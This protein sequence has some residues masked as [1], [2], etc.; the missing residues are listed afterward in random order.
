MKCLIERP[1]P[2]DVT[3]ATSGRRSFA[4]SPLFSHFTWGIACRTLMDPHG[5]LF[6]YLEVQFFA[7]FCRRLIHLAGTRYDALEDR[8]MGF[9]SVSAKGITTG[10]RNAPKA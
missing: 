9:R 8:P 4:Y 5:N 2:A 10:T 1:N 7:P 6:C 3:D